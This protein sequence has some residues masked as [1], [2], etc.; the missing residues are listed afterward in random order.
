L[1][2]NPS[3][4]SLDVD[5]ALAADFDER[6]PVLLIHPTKNS[7]GLSFEIVGYLRDGDIAFK[8]ISVWHLDTAFPLKDECR[9]YYARRVP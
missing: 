6:Q 2:E 8:N 4:G 1:I 5:E 3:A 9:T 7:A